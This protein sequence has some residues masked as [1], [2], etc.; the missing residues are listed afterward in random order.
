MHF[1][2]EVGENQFRR[3]SKDYNGIQVMTFAADDS[4][5]KSAKGSVHIYL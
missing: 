2:E 3:V 1:L 4:F 5:E